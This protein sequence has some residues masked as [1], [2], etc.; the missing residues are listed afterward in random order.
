MSDDPFALELP[1]ATGTQQLPLIDAGGAGLTR[2]QQRV[3]DDLLAIGGD[4][5]TSPAGLADELDAFLAERTTGPLAAWEGTLWL[6][7]SLMVTASR[8]EGMIVADRAAGRRGRLPAATVVG[9]VAHRAVQLSY[10]DPDLTVTDYVRH[11]IVGARRS[12]DGVATWWDEADLSERS[13]L[14]VTAEGKL[15][16]F[17]DSWPK[18]HETW[19]PRFE[20]SLQHKVGKLTLAGRP[21]LTLGRPKADRRQTMVLV[22]LKTGSLGEHHEAEADLYALVATLRHGVAPYRSCV[23]SLASGDWTTPDV[24][25]ERL[26]RAAEQVASAVTS[27]VETVALDRTPVL[28]AGSWCRW[29]PAV[30]CPSRAG[31]DGATL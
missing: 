24:T 29:C 22:D 18:L 4:R 9:I 1:S 17:L 26:W 20:H 11:A 3:L 27:L 7:K 31:G 23:Y 14:V 5:P 12:D 10:T 19:N 15:T 25:P 30:E 6:S 8:C 2:A 16:S 21:D 28:T 13:D